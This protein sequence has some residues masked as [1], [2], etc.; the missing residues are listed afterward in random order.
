MSLQPSCPFLLSMDGK[1]FAWLK[2]LE[3][4]GT[5]PSRCLSS[6]SWP[7]ETFVCFS[8]VRQVCYPRRGGW[9][10]PLKAGTFGG[11]SSVTGMCRV[12]SREPWTVPSWAHCTGQLAK[13]LQTVK[14]WLDIFFF[15]DN[16]HSWLLRLKHSLAHEWRDTVISV[17]GEENIQKGFPLSSLTFDLF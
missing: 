17:F 12:P 1:G 2:P 4:S 14:L 8:V 13:L 16:C 15:F 11:H 5:G 10:C 7:R 6:L 9:F 3:G